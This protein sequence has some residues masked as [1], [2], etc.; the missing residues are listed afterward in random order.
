MTVVL[1]GLI[2]FFRVD[3]YDTKSCNQWKFHNL[4][5]HSRLH[6]FSQISVVDSHQKGTHLYALYHGYGLN[7][8][9]LYALGFVVGAVTSPFIGPLVDKYGRRK[10]AVIYCFLEMIINA[11]EQYNFLPGIIASRLIGGVTTNL[12][13][14]VF[15]SWLITEHRSRGFPESQLALL[16]RD[17][18]VSSNLSAIG[19][20]F[21]AHF[22]ADSFGPAGPFKGT[23]VCSGIALILVATQWEENYGSCVTNTQSLWNILCEL[24]ED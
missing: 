12:L 13:F 2:Y 11:L 14:T 10:S 17:S 3:I 8:P 1:D 23:V 4:A 7:V 24:V 16:L 6:L 19:S 15:E 18:V 20:G 22:L 21:L 9:N 5:V